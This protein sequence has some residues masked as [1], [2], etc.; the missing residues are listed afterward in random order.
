MS[1]DCAGILV[2][3]KNFFCDIFS[4][5]FRFRID[6]FSR[7]ELLS[8]SQHS[9]RTLLSAWDNADAEQIRGAAVQADLAPPMSSFEAERIEMIRVAAGVL[10]EWTEG[11]ASAAEVDASLTLLRHLAGRLV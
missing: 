9:A 7:M 10:H 8:S 3:L 2:F 1:M 5:L 11:T 4:K 6:M